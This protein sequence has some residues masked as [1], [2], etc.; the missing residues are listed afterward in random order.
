[1]K[2]ISGFKDSEAWI[3]GNSTLWAK[4]TPMGKMGTFYTYGQNASSCDP[5][6]KLL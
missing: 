3:Q 4:C 2:T 6:N 1:M 5:L